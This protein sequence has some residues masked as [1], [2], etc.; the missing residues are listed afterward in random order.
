MP[1]I[2]YL[3]IITALTLLFLSNLIAFVI[4]YFIFYIFILL[5]KW[6]NIL[7]TF[8]ISRWTRFHLFFYMTLHLT[9]SSLQIPTTFSISFILFHYND[10]FHLL[11]F[12]IRVDFFA[13]LHFFYIWEWINLLNLKK[14]FLLC[15]LSFFFCSVHLLQTLFLI[16][17]ILSRNDNSMNWIYFNNS[18]MISFPKV[19]ISFFSLIF[20]AVKNL[21]KNLMDKLININATK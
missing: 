6:I 12:F 18:D 11:F 16:F 17:K 15:L 2:F 20:T 7:F 10:F 19:F 3:I 14:L 21:V 8:L 4:I 1:R 13:A 9:S 5:R